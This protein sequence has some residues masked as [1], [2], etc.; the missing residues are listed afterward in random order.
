MNAL[1]DFAKKR[2][3][4]E[5]DDRP[6]PTS[7]AA[8]YF[9]LLQTHFWKLITLNLIFVAF[10]IPVITLPAAL[11]GLNRALIK[12]IREG[13]CFLWHEFFKEFRESF[14][15]SLL[16]GMIFGGGLFAAYYGLSLGLTN[17]QSIFGMIFS[18]MGIFALMLAL[19]MGGWAFVLAAM[20]P[21][22]IRDILRNARALA[23]LDK[24]CSA[25]VLGLGLSLWLFMLMLMP[26]SIMG[27][28]FLL[29]AFVQYTICFMVNEAVEVHIFAPYDAMGG[30]AEHRQKTTRV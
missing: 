27:G 28:A 20:L 23:F 16:L 13:H 12:L 21:L 14:A 2:W 11:C 8:R 17:A 6:V 10:S 26:V 18:A 30:E 9:F 5:G 4:K 3:H 22:G 25:A 1:N 7:G 29:I 15:K 19:L 24:K